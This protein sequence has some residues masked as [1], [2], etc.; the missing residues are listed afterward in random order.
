[1]IISCPRFN[2]VVWAAWSTN[3]DDRPSFQEVRRQ[4]QQTFPEMRIDESDYGELYEY[5]EAHVEEASPFDIEDCCKGDDIYD[6]TEVQKA[7]F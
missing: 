2:L 4:L 5:I 1:M 3:P 7:V 6:D